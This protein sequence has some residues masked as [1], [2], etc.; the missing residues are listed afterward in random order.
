VLDHLVLAVAP[1]IS[2]A[3]TN[4][5]TSLGESSALS[6]KRHENCPLKGIDRLLLEEAIQTKKEKHN[7]L[8]DQQS[9]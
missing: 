9:N 3:E 2:T 1:K 6:S 5:L 4:N 7:T 8:T